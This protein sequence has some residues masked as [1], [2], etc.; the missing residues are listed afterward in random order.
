[1]TAGRIVACTDRSHG[2]GFTSTSVSFASNKLGLMTNAVSSFV[3]NVA[4]FVANRSIILASHREGYLA[5][6]AQAAIGDAEV[7]HDRCRFTGNPVL[8]TLPSWLGRGEGTAR[9]CVTDSRCT[10]LATG[11][12]LSGSGEAEGAGGQAAIDIGTEQRDWQDP[13]KVPLKAGP[14]SLI[15]VGAAKSLATRRVI[16]SVHDQVRHTTRGYR[17][18]SVTLEVKLTGR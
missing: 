16:D 6:I 8:G 1:M 7:D 3:D 18:P 10:Q 4:S 14:S 12:P 9:W 13:P 2:Q 15:G 17:I 5:S 11:T